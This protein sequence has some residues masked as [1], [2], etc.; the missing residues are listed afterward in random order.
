M[1]SKQSQ[2][3]SHHQ[4]RIYKKTAIENNTLSFVLASIFPL[5]SVRAGGDTRSA[6]NFIH[7]RPVWLWSKVVS[8]IINVT[9]AMSSTGGLLNT[10]IGVEAFK[11]MESWRYYFEPHWTS[12]S[13]QSM[14][15][16]T[17]CVSKTW[18]WRLLGLQSMT[19]HR[20]WRTAIWLL[21][22]SADSELFKGSFEDSRVC[23][24]ALWSPLNH[25]PRHPS[26][27]PSQQSLQS[28]IPKV[29]SS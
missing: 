23:K 4:W 2:N 21:K 24:V 9:T 10:L 6:W 29:F 19:S 7:S 12:L 25:G 17:R 13:L 27:L 18:L 11:T 26:T 14:T 8:V 28:M 20:F 15:L 16:K 5:L 3:A 22:T 1:L